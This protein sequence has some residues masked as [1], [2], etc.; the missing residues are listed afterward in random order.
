MPLAWRAWRL[1]KQ[2]S[3]TTVYKIRDP[4]KKITYELEGIQKAFEKFYQAL[5]T[6]PT[7]FDNCKA[8]SFLSQ[9]DLPSLGKLHHDK[10][11]N[12]ISAEK[13]L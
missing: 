2:Q 1:R 7:P 5:N 9:L 6:Q 13:I 4:T 11:I 8:K 12:E 3:K 10:L